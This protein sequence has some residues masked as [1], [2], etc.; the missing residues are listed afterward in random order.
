MRIPAACVLLL[1]IA[2]FAAQP[3]L[4]GE[5]IQWIADYCMAKLETD[6]EIA[7]GDCIGK[8]LERKFRSD[9]EAKVHFKR[10]LCR[11]AI[12]RKTRK[13][14]LDSCVADAAFMGS[15]VRNGGVGGMAR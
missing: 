14:G 3:A 11:L 8:G 7:A 9:A 15:T 4:Q 5:K 2:A 1:P 13:G 12:A 10:E 6:D